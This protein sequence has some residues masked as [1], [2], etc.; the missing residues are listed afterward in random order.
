[1]WRSL[2]VFG[3]LGFGEGWVRV[4]LVEQLVHQLVLLL[5]VQIADQRRHLSH[6]LF[7][8]LLMRGLLLG[9][10]LV[11]LAFG[12]LGDLDFLLLVGGRPLRH[13]L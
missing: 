10:G 3:V 13:Q 8:F 12:L 5:Q 11:L 1:M 9:R 7:L 2:L 4:G 6:Y